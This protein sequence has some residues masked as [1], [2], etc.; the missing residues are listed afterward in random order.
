MLELDGQP[1]A[2][3]PEEVD[4]GWRW[5]VDVSASATTV[6]LRCRADAPPCWSMT[7]QTPAPEP[8]ALTQARALRSSSN[9]AEGL[10]RRLQAVEGLEVALPGYPA[11]AR[12]AALDV[13]TDLRLQAA[14]AAPDPARRREALARALEWTD[15]AWAHAVEH[16]ET[17][18]GSCHARRALRYAIEDLGDAEQ[19]RRWGRRLRSLP[20][21]P[22]A[23]AGMNT[24]YL[25]IEAQRDGD[26]QTARVL[27]LEA[28][29]AGR[30]FDVWSLQRA[31]LIQ[32]ATVLSSFGQEQEVE[33][34]FGR[35]RAQQRDQLGCLAWLRV[36]N[37]HSWARYQLAELGRPAEDP[38]PDLDD[39]LLMLGIRDG[40][41]PCYSPELLE[42]AR[43]N[44]GLV[45]VDRGWL[46]ESA[47]LLEQVRAAEPVAVR[48]FWV[49]LLE[50]R[51]VL[52]RRDHGE[53]AEWVMRDQP[54]PPG[55]PPE[56]RWLRYFGR[57][58]V[59]EA[60]D[61]PE[62]A[63]V[64]YRRSEDALDSMTRALEF[65]VA[66]ERLLRGR[67]SSAGRLVALLAERGQ[68][69]AAVCAARRARRRT[70]DALDR[71]ARVAAMDELQ[72]A[73]WRDALAQ[74][75]HL[76]AELE[77]LHEQTWTVPRDQLPAHTRRLRDLEQLHAAATRRARAVL[78]GADLDPIG[79]PSCQGWHALGPAEVAL[80]YFPIDREG[81]R[82]QG[83]ASTREGMVHT[84][85]VELPPGVDAPLADWSAALLE[86]FHD[87]IAE[88]A[89]L[90]ILP[91]GRLWSVPFAALPFDGDVLVRRA[92]VSTSLDLTPRA[93]SSAQ[94]R[95]A[96]IVG[97]PE[98]DLPSARR[99]SQR[100]AEALPAPA[101]SVTSLVG[102]QAE[103]SAL[104]ERLPAVDLFHFAGHA[105]HEGNDGWGS[106]L[107]L[108]GR[109]QLQ[110]RDVLALPRVPS[111]VVLSA[112]DTA[113]VA[114]GTLGGGMS[115]ARAFLLAGADVVV[116]SQSLLDD[117]LGLELAEALYRAA[118][119]SAAEA[120]AALRQALLA[121]EGRF[122]DRQWSPVV[123]L[124][125]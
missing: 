111:V 120:P 124:V 6:A 118:P 98:G 37:N 73:R 89:V 16:G 84:A 29:R 31:G 51:L 81:R 41:D 125:P 7:M 92:V 77:R 116:A 15:R 112:C 110:V 63:I 26:L 75:Q 19:A 52:A 28:E 91:T 74:A 87:T 5:S 79:G 72:R 49:E 106:G 61:L 59:L 69:A 40:D 32:A 34:L 47:R 96:L 22:E 12:G 45:A 115:I 9:D 123:A 107:R 80:L 66:H 119:R 97:D 122:E 105:R 18:R 38:V 58:Q 113:S 93:L 103:A 20:D 44:L 21:V 60:L 71:P 4:G 109:G 108:A 83:F 39:V 46:G 82:W 42:H 23:T 10:E 90:R 8:S 48:R 14:R 114:P 25:G 76:R 68:T 64:A 101:W 1:V 43:L 27:Y 50:Q 117:R 62:D 54:P 33:A 30:R 36:V 70:H 13:I 2:I 78:Y 95:E 99:E 57:G 94:A 86:P 67:Q 85:V 35:A 104:L 88:A 56:D 17:D 121:V 53:L 3:T 55:A 11:A 102:P 100:V 65:D 24:Y